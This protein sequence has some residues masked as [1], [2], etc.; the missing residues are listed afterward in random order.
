MMNMIDVYAQKLSFYASMMTAEL[1]I[2]DRKEV[3]DTI[4]EL[5][6]KLERKVEEDV[7]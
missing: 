3:M 7:A 1:N 6:A 2:A 5:V 4:K